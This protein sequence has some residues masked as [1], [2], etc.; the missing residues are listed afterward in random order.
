MSEGIVG[1]GADLAEYRSEGFTP[2]LLYATEH[3]KV[4]LAAFEPG[5]QIPLHEPRVDLALTVLEGTGDVLVGDK[6]HHVRAGDVVVAPAG[7]KRGVRAREGRL[8]VLHVVS[9]PPTE[10]DHARVVGGEPWPYVAEHSAGHRLG[11]AVHAE[12]EHLHG[13]IEAL[14]A[15]SRDIPSL[16]DRELGARLNAAVSFL[17]GGLL[18]HARAEEELLY[19]AVEKVLRAVG[20]ATRTMQID[21]R[22]ITERIDRLAALAAEAPSPAVR[23]EAARALIG[24]EALL[25]V[26]FVKEEEVYVPLLDRLGDEE[27]AALAEALLGPDGSGHHAH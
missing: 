6:I 8:V 7:V 26:H 22:A 21:H 24:L 1:R 5:Q 19:P 17:R 23:E 13:E 16:D 18:P 11:E 9:P 12:H 3:F 4:V 27:A 14:G 25:G 10:A 15:L 2:K 20:G